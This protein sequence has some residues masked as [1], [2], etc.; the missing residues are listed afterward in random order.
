MCICL[1]RSLTFQPSL[2][3]LS[4]LSQTKSLM[5]L[6]SH[7]NIYY[8]KLLLCPFCQQ[9]SWL[10]KLI[11]QQVDSN[12]NKIRSTKI[13]LLL[14]FIHMGFIH[15]CIPIVGTPLQHHGQSIHHHT[16][17]PIVLT[18]RAP[19]GLPSG[20]LLPQVLL[21]LLRNTHKRHT[22][23]IELTDSCLHL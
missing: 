11:W 17:C 5:F 19:P 12:K 2:S 1:L 16:L 7:L 4:L 23:E 10:Q 3:L 9:R 20:S 18:D 13:L 8:N 22:T 6:C 21:A 15:T 14:Y